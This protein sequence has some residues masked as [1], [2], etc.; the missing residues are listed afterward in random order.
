MGCG[1]T[2][3][4]Q[5][6]LFRSSQ[7]TL[8]HHSETLGLQV[9]NFKTTRVVQIL[10]Y[11]PNEGRDHDCHVLFYIPAPNALARERVHK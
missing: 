8:R 10:D 3:G 6:D 4:T 5:L 9:T 11:E 7:Q 2:F 1:G